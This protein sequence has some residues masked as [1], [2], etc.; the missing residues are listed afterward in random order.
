MMRAGETALA[1]A[2][3]SSREEGSID[4]LAW[5]DRLMFD[6]FGV[7][8]AIRINQPN[9]MRSLQQVLPPG[10]VASTSCRAHRRFSLIVGAPDAEESGQRVNLLYEG[11]ERLAR[12]RELAPVLKLLEIKLRR[13][14][15][16]M[17]PRR[18]FVHAGVVAYRGRA[19]VIPGRTM[20]GKSTLVAE[21]IKRGAT[22][23]SDEYAVLDEKGLVHPFAKPVSL[24]TAGTFD[25]IDYGAEHFGATIGIEPAAIGLV[26]ITRYLAGAKW[27][28]RAVTHGQGALA[29]LAH[30]IA[31]RRHPRRVMSTLRNALAEAM[32]LKGARGEAAELSEQL[33]ERLEHGAH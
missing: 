32:I 16:E 11:R 13:T 6:S 31:A 26:V 8:L 3:H 27:Q 22:Y 1:Q 25:A 24:R 23:F 21:L 18:V 5:A 30:C 2:H 4:R 10:R 9:L 20:S 7:R 28:P 19:I 17:A 14:V 33:L 12:Q 29:V 15:A